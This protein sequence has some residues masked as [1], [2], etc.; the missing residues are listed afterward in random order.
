MGFV[1]KVVVLCSAPWW[2]F[3]HGLSDCFV[4]TACV[5]VLVVA[6]VDVVSHLH[7]RDSQCISA[8]T[9]SLES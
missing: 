3:W 8:W 1:V 5:A 7:V 4:V 2:C 9:L 6:D